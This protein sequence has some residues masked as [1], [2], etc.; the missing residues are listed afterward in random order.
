MPGD[1]G[2]APGP[3]TRGV[4]PVLGVRPVRG[5]N[6]VRGV[7]PVLGVRPVR[8][9]EGSKWISCC[10]G[11]SS[12]AGDR[13]PFLRDEVRDGELIGQEYCCGASRSA[14]EGRVGRSFL[15]FLSLPP[16]LSLPSDGAKDLSKGLGSWSKS[17]LDCLPG[18]TGGRSRV[19]VE[20]SVDLD[21]AVV[22]FNGVLG[23]GKRRNDDKQSDA[24]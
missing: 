4:R 16:S 1:E 3:P 7:R 22:I 9:E 14:S 15:S 17:D 11:P 24:L 20:D 12:N 18:R 2:K 13:G 21:A 8:K 6:P 19:V 10:F 5:V 23:R